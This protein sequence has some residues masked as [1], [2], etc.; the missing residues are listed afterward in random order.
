MTQW[1]KKS[2]IIIF[3]LFV[4]PSMMN[5]EPQPE[6]KEEAMAVKKPDIA[7]DIYMRD[8]ICRNKTPIMMDLIF[9]NTSNKPQKICT[10]KFYD[11]LLKLQ[12]YNAKQEQIEFEPTLIQAGELSEEDWVVIPPKRMYKRSFS[13]T[14][15]IVASTGHRLEPG[16]YKIKAIYEGCNK[17]DPSLPPFAI[18]SNQLYFMVIE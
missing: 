2:L 8:G 12:L 5:G 9:K 7:L 1:I 6:E 18:E 14:R 10:Y 3:I 4:A 11:S 13:L 16:S 17:F 15:K